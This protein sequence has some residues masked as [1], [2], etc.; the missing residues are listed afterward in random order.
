M[1]HSTTHFTVMM[2]PAPGIPKRIVAQTTAHPHLLIH[3]NVITWKPRL[4]LGR[5]YGISHKKSGLGLG[6][7]A[8]S[9]RE[10]ELISGALLGVP[11]NWRT[12][13][14]KNCKQQF[15]AL[16]RELQLWLEYLWGH[17]CISDR[18]F[19]QLRERWENTKQRRR[20]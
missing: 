7:F 2:G 1:K 14:R 12:L 17:L 15:E 13:N 16:P 8:L 18:R 5:S 19:N 11:F 10:A 9:R 4:R 3:R 20:K 6:I